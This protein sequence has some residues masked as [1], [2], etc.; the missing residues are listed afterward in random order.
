MNRYSTLGKRIVA[1]LIDS[2]IFAPFIYLY[3]NFSWSVVPVWID[4]LMIPLGSVLGIGYNVLLHWKY[5]QTVGKMVAKVKV[6][7]ISEQPI[8]FGQAFLRD[9]VYV[10]DG[11]INSLLSYSFFAFGYGAASETYQATMQYVVIP[12]IIWLIVDTIVCIKNRKHRALHDFIAGTVVV[13]LDIAGELRPGK[14]L[15]PPGPEHYF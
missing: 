6:V 4:Y 15:E 2:L 11:S 3:L 5:G 8:S 13:R 7:D 10:I 1:Y 9:I 14:I 12:I